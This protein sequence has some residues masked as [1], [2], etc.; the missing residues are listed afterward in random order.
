MVEFLNVDT[1]C[2]SYRS[3]LRY[4]FFFGFSFSSLFDNKKNRKRNRFLTANKK[5]IVGIKMNNQVRFGKKLNKYRI[6]ALI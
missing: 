4:S 1:M 3:F 6:N 5:Q 2:T